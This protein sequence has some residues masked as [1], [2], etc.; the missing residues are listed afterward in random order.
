MSERERER[1]RERGG[2][3]G[4]REKGEGERG[5]GRD[6]ER[7]GEQRRVGVG[8]ETAYFLHCLDSMTLTTT[9]PLTMGCLSK[10]RNHIRLDWIIV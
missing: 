4:G 5:R 9:T 8:A 3:E 1:E 10:Q 6:G 2:G 7:G